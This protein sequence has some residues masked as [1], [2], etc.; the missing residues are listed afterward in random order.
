MGYF[1]TLSRF[2]RRF[3]SGPFPGFQDPNYVFGIPYVVC[4][5]CGH[6]RRNSKRLV[7]AA[8][9][10]VHVVQGD[11]CR[12]ALQLLGERIGEPRKPAHL[13]SHC[14]VLPLDI[15]RGYVVHVGIASNDL[16]VN[17]DAFRRGIAR[18]VVGLQRLPVQF[19]QQA[20][21]A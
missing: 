14:E 21:Q 15:G 10:V 17:A 11:G 7:D 2:H 4:N 3:V 9:V 13:H 1:Q 5:S 18:F 20:R 16:G 6:C 12:M 19:N 8:E